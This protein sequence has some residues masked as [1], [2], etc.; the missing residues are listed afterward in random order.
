MTD[1]TNLI[2]AGLK[3]EFDRLLD[4]LPDFLKTFALGDATRQSRDFG[5][6][7]ALISFVHYGP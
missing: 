2:V 4:V 7:S 1:W 6:K 3:P 5:P